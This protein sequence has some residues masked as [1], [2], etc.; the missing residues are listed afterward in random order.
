MSKIGQAQED[1]QKEKSES[2][3]RKIRSVESVM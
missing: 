3:R 2:C 1:G